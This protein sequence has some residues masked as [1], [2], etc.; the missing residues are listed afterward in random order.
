MQGGGKSFPPLVSP[1]SLTERSDA[2][3]CGALLSRQS[4]RLLN[5]QIAK[6]ECGW[7]STKQ[8]NPVLLSFM[9]PMVLESLLE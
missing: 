8:A 7:S 9:L 2:S 6:R 4:A 5:E 1:I 3:A